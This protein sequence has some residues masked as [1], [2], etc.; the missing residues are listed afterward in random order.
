MS[1]IFIFI[2]GVGLGET[3]DQNPFTRLEPSA[4]RRMA[5]DRPFTEGVEPILESNYLFKPVDACLG[6]EG[7]PQS[8]TGQ[9]TLFSGENA[10]EILGRHFGP[11][12][13]SEIKYLL[14]EKSLFQKAGKSGAEC[15]FMNA[16]PELF[17]QRARKRQRWT[18]TTLMARNAGVPLQREQDVREGRAITAEIINNVWRERLEIDL[19]EMSPQEAADRIH[20]Q[21][22]Q[23]DVILYEYFLTDKVG[24]AQDMEWGRQ[25]LEILNPFLNRL[26][27]AR[28]EGDSLVLSSDHGNMEDLSQK[29]HTLNRVPLFAGGPAAAHLKEAESIADITGGIL[30]TLKE[31][32]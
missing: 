3:G 32:T 27:D 5:G 1:V 14:E 20:R 8:G 15:H 2:D 21:A 19:P 23:K 18:C 24:H 13:H 29:M 4:F 6:V 11:F 16:Y 9:A 12:P 26:M 7:L 30:D 25:I 31:E 22:K 10:S 17:F 28:R